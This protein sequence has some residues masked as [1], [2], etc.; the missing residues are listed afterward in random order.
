MLVSY[1]KLKRFG[2]G[3][4]H[5]KKLNGTENKEGWGESL[6]LML[7]WPGNLGF[8]LIIR[9]RFLF[10][11]HGPEPINSIRITAHQLWFSWK[12]EVKVKCFI[13]SDKRLFLDQEYFNEMRLKWI[14]DIGIKC[15][16]LIS[17]VC[18][19]C[20]QLWNVI[21]ARELYWGL[22]HHRQG[23]PGGSELICLKIKYVYINTW[24]KKAALQT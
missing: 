4:N 15:C 6:V 13:Y 20:T 1:L 3:G 9:T 18:L 23:F 10:Q 22:P 2:E 17:T 24:G 11:S 19:I 8:P 7:S 14:V 12:L 16:H 21:R 5:P